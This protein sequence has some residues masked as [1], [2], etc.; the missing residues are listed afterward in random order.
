MLGI[1]WT[2]GDVSPRGFEALRLSIWGAWKLFGAAAE[3]LV[4]V[5]TVPVRRARQL[6]G[7]VPGAVTWRA[8]DTHLPPWLRSACLDAGMAE[9]VAWKFAPL[10]C[11]P[12]A[13]EL[14]LDNDVILWDMPAALAAWLADPRPARCLLAEDVVPGFGR[15][16][17][18]CG[19]RALNSGIR[20]L[21]AG[22]DLEA[23]LRAVLAE[24]P[25]TLVSELDEQGLQAAALSRGGEP[26]VVSVQDVTICSPFPPHLPGLGACGAHF[27]GLNARRLGWDFHG[28]PAERVRARHWEQHRAALYERVGVAPIEHGSAARGGSQ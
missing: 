21:P 28:E 10:R 2:I 9:G 17:A 11:F 13:R 24:H 27:V 8:A 20:G 4:L 7:P 26:Y 22:F 14:S 3:Y 16:A 12:H 19:A 6:A 5:N 23:R 18:L 1:R 25:V 15:F